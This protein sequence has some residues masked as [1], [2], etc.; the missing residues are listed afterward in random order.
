[1]AISG[2]K[3]LLALGSPQWDDGHFAVVIVVAVTAVAA[4]YLV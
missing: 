2:T 3:S 4:C 1:M